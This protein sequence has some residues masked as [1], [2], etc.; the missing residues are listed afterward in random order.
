MINRKW[1]FLLAIILL[2]T[3]CSLKEETPSNEEITTDNET[4]TG[5]EALTTHVSE[6][7]DDSTPELLEVEV[8]K[9][10]MG[11]VL[12][13]NESDGQ[14][15]IYDTNS[16]DGNVIATLDDYE[17]VELVETVPFGWFKLKLE[18]GREGYGE[19][20]SI[21][22]EEIPP[23]DYNKD[24][25]EYVLI[26]THEDQTLKIFKDGDL[27]K[28]SLGSSGIWDSFT[29]RGVFQIEDGRRGE[30]SYIERFGVGLKYWVGFRWIYLFHSVPFDKDG[31]IIEEEAEKI[32]QPASHGCIRLPVDA[33]KYI[34]DN[35]PEGSIVL[36]Y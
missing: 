2:V 27:V 1:I 26:F 17:K 36:I 5:Q 21:R 24:S 10:Y 9:V 29:P 25:S 28:E 6:G 8:V 31:N 11:Q 7:Q 4:A 13:T 22:T 3:G 20:I 34:Y 18:D 30:W 16:Y 19:A 35:I 33:A 12:D 14:I 23:H 32:G 15:N